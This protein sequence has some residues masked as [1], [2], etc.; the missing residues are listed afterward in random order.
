MIPTVCAV[1]VPTDDD[2]IGALSLIF[3][4]L[5][6]VV[7][8]KYVRMCMDL[9]RG[10]N[11]GGVMALLMKIKKAVRAS[12][13]DTSTHLT[14]RS[15]DLSRE[16]AAQYYNFCV[17]VAII[18]AGSMLADATITPA[19]SILRHT[20]T[21]HHNRNRRVAFYCSCCYFLSA[22]RWRVWRTSISRRPSLRS[23]CRTLSCPSP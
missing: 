17:V 8:L 21:H 6:V 9:D 20:T 22:V 19:L 12:T 23:G 3:Y 1:Q 10:S 2:L 14:T 7:Y 4:V 15:I 5:F 18:G 13:E 11:E 16:S